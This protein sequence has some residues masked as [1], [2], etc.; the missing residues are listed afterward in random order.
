MIKIDQA[1]NPETKSIYSFYQNPGIGYYIPLYQRPYSWDKDN[2]EQL[3]DDIGKGVENMLTNEKDEIRFLGT[4]ISVIETNK[5]S[6]EPQDPTGLPGTIENIIDGQQRLSTIS[7]LSVLLYY[8]INALQQQLLKKEEVKHDIDE[9]CTKWKNKLITIFS[10]D[11]ERGKP[12]RKPKIIRGNKDAWTKDG[13]L[14]QYY[15]SPVAKYLALGVQNLE[16]EKPKLPKTTKDKDDKVHSNTRLFKSWISS[17]VQKAHINNDD[18]FPSAKLIL[19][20]FDQDHLWD[21]ERENIEKIVNDKSHILSD[22]I[23]Q[24]VQTVAACHYLLD[25]CCFTSIQPKNDDWAFDMFQ[26]LNAT[27]TPLT[28]IETF[29]PIVVQTVNEKEGS[30]KRSNAALSFKKVD[31]L[32][33]DTK[34]AAQKSKLSNDYLV[35][36]RLIIDGSKL[37]SHF[38][39]QRKWLTDLYI[40]KCSNYEEKTSIVNFFGNFSSFYKDIWLLYDGSDNAII[41]K[42]KGDDDSELASLLILFLKESNHKMAITI[43]GFFYSHVIEGKSGSIKDFINSVKLITSFYILWRSTKGNSG[44]DNVYREFL[45]GKEGQVSAHNLLETGGFEVNDLKKYFID[46]LKNNKIISETDWINKASKNLRYSNIKTICKFSLFCAFHDT[47]PDGDTGLMKK[48]TKNCNPYLTLEKWVS[49]DLK[50]IEHIAPETKTNSWSSDLYDEDEA[51]HLVGNC[52]LLPIDLNAS[53]GNKSIKEKML[54]YKHVSEKDITERK[55]LSN[56]AKALG[57]TLS[58][59]TIELLEKCSY[60][61]HLESTIKINESQ[62][63]DKDFVR[64]RT[65]RIATLTYKNIAEWLK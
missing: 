62:D 15:K 24:L 42:I 29:H 5:S 34:T 44:L 60:N 65:E 33:K 10:L 2:V 37:E 58:K 18:D 55:E 41:D 63:W 39:K 27:G 51:F 26:S 56:A 28:A 46:V 3:L 25:R 14:S 57:V 7:M 8:S 16:E 9:I 48:G 31:D 32:F 59:E 52:T 19:K 54:Y 64:T 1:F 49:K 61:S 45:K 12:S 13:E 4:I 11:L 6:I 22:K 35:A 47:I 43:L 53:A 30:Y 17:T 20:K 38:S 36:L 50:T 21:Y 23:S 40:N